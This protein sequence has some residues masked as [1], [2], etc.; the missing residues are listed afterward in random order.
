M[1]VQQLVAM[2]AMGLASATSGLQPQQVTVHKLKFVA[3]EDVAKSVTNYAEFKKLSVELS[4]DLRTNSVIV[5]GD[6]AQQKQVAGIIAAIDKEPETIL[7]EMTI[8]EAPATFAEDVGL[9]EGETWVLT[10]REAKMLAATIRSRESKDVQ[11]R[12]KSQL[13]LSDNQQ[14]FVQIV[15]NNQEQE[16][17]ITP[18]VTPDKGSNILRI[19]AQFKSPSQLPNAK[20]TQL[21][22]TTVSVKDAH[23][24]VIRGPRTKKVNEDSRDILIILAVHNVRAER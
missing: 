2:L 5:T 10:L 6:L 22:E 14:G 24:V 19:Y 15:N 7:T 12:S 9:G 20:D 1:M 16:F 8:L 3:A 13:L 11:I 4:T 17:R 18:R 21:I 23:S